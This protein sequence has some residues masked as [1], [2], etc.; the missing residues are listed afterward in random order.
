[1]LDSTRMWQIFLGDDM[2]KHVWVDA[3]DFRYSN[4]M[5]YANAARCD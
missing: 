3:V 5:R 1:L 4:W 2:L